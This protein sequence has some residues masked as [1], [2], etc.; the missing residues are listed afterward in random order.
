[1]L[2]RSVETT[3]Y[4]YAF[5]I[6][7][8]ADICRY[9]RRTWTHFLR[10]MCFRFHWVSAFLRLFT[11]WIRQRCEQFG[12]FFWTQIS[13]QQQQWQH[14]RCTLFV[15][16]FWHSSFADVECDGCGANKYTRAQHTR[17]RKMNC[18]HKSWCWSLEISLW[19]SSIAFV[20]RRA[21][22]FVVVHAVTS[23]G[24]VEPCAVKSNTFACVVACAPSCGRAIERNERNVLWS[25]GAP[26]NS[27]TKI[28]AKTTK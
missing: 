12:I 9:S 22:E 5:A 7:I 8:F 2:C 26:R 17:Q 28:D 10:L 15:Y 21:N 25:T 18:K 24:R 27:P 19:F 16:I 4:Y 14:S 20:F 13:R 11:I 23:K 3:D 6:F 1:M